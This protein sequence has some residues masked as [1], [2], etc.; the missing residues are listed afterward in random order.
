VAAGATEVFAGTWT[1]GAPWA[2]VSF[3]RSFYI[4]PGMNL[5]IHWKDSNTTTIA[6]A[7]VAHNAPSRLYGWGW[8]NNSWADAMASSVSS[9]NQRNNIRIYTMLAF[10]PYLGNNLS[11]MSMSSPVDDGSVCERDYSPTRINVVNVGADTW[12]F[13][14]NNVDIAYEI[15]IPTGIIYT[16]I[17]PVRSGSLA[18]ENTRIVEL[19]PQ[20]PTLY[21]GS[22]V[23]KAWLMNAPD[24]VR[25]DDTITYTYHSKR[26]SVPL[27][28]YFTNPVLSTEFSTTPLLG[29]DTWTPYQPVPPDH[30][31]PLTS[32]GVLRYAGTAGSM[33]VFG[34]RQLELAGAINPRLDFWYYHDAT[35]PVDDDSYTE[36]IVVTDNVPHV[37]MALLRRNGNGWTKYSVDLSPYT[38]ARCALI[39]FQSMNGNRT[40]VSEQFIDRIFITSDIDIEVSSITVSPE[41]TA[42]SVCNLNNKTVS[43]VIRSTMNQVIDFSQH[44]TNLRVEIP[45]MSPIIYPL[46]SGTILGYRTITIPI[47]SNVSIPKGTH[48]LRAYLTPPIDNLNMNDTAKLFL[49]I[50]PDL[51]IMAS[52]L[53]ADPDCQPNGST[54]KQDVTVKNTGNMNIQG[55]T[56]ELRIPQ[57]LLVL[58]ETIQTNLA[59][60]ESAIVTF[61][62]EVP[63]MLDYEV[64]IAAYMNCDKTLVSDTVFFQE[65]VEINDLAVINAIVHQGEAY[66]IDIMNTSNDIEVILQ[67][68]SRYVDYSNVNIYAQ[69]EG[70]I[71]TTLADVVP[72]VNFSDTT[73]FRFKEK[74]L[75]PNRKGDYF[76]KVFIE[77]VDNIPS[78]DTLLITRT[79]G[80]KTGISSAVANMFSLG[81]NIPNPAKNSTM[82]EYSI[83]EQGE[84]IF[85]VHSISGQLLYTQAIQSEFGKHFIELNISDFAAGIYIYSVEYKGQKL[86]KRMSVKN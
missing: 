76:I 63:G 48:T 41:I 51:T 67:N 83:P 62:Y 86:V 52:P 10:N 39:E 55:I 57:V 84:V 82:I 5:E 81:Q 66:E 60:G 59:P 14:V 47:A 7:W 30:V 80:Q 21:A 23:I 35:A 61:N 8:S 49:D 43:V 78:N 79:A 74:Y 37:E 25:L 29:M 26:T 42:S 70:H 73:L 64:R 50:R 58:Q 4:P 71:A 77:S 69:V 20:L 1:T 12:D 18:S 38:K 56:V 75:V 68:V 53:S 17:V 16:G 9:G 13:S 22:Y 40:G 31:Q 44:P 72:I 11:L 28:E 2:A 32:T 27:D 85:N 33:S 15:T 24:S 36:V 19:M 65:C 46:T 3:Q 34:T 45:G 6:G 54:A